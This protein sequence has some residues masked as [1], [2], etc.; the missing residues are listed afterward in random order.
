MVVIRWV[1]VAALVAGGGACKQEL[2]ATEKLQKG[3]EELKAGHRARARTLLQDGLKEH[4]DEAAYLVLAQIMLGEGELEQAAALVDKGLKT[5][6][7]SAALWALQAEL[8][9]GRGRGAKAIEA[10]HRA[11]DLKPG[12]ADLLL[13]WASLNTSEATAISLERL[14]S[15]ALGAEP[16][17]EALVVQADVL[18]QTGRTD[19]ARHVREASESAK[20]GSADRAA[21]LGRLMLL[22]PVPG[23][24]P[25]ER[26]LRLAASAPDASVDL[27]ALHAQVALDL[28]R[29]KQAATSLH[30][31]QARWPKDRQPGPSFHLLQGRLALAQGDPASAVALLEPLSKKPE[32]LDPAQRSLL[33]SALGRALVQIEGRVSAGKALL[34]AV[35]ANALGYAEAQTALAS[36]EFQAAK[37]GEDTTAR[38]AALSRL[39]K[40]IQLQPRYEAAY[41]MLATAQS[42]AG[43]PAAARKTLERGVTMVPD[44]AL[45]WYE[46]GRTSLDER[47]VRAAAELGKAVDLAPTLVAA[48][49]LLAEAMQRSGR[50]EQAMAIYEQGLQLAPDTLPWM[51]NLASL[52]ADQG[53]NLSRASELAE[54]AFELGK[55]AP[56][57]ADTLGW[58]VARSGDF[59]RAS[60]LVGLAAESMP[61]DG[62]VLMHLA[63]VQAGLGDDRTAKKTLSK[64][65]KAV[66]G[67]PRLLAKIDSLQLPQVRSTGTR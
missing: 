37:Q 8:L 44:S 64:A 7:R 42:E 1:L 65:R 62:E 29:T 41:G 57:L 55:Q 22:R 48:R 40:L 21:A 49:P 52:Y 58:V 5:F 28:D 61:E 45:L 35:P 18:G 56:A 63:Y 59:E 30:A 9:A 60:K 6:P 4:E 32:A 16:A 38:G 17:A 43:Q 50:A 31:A 15:R 26:L 46:L 24:D 13:R 19:R 67:R 25:A 66:A 10:Y 11:S 33:K 51:N 53:E 54:R 23:L 34:D 27:L 36:L 12:D 39:S 14:L 3:Q 20:L 2:T 47:P